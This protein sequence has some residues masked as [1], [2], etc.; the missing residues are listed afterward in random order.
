[1]NPQ[2]VTALERFCEGLSAELRGSESG[3]PPR[4][5]RVVDDSAVAPGGA[6]VET[7]ETTVDATVA[8]RVE[9]IADELLAGWRVRQKKLGLET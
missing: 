2:A 9:K 8:A 6:I 3:A 4:H 1:V 7:A 5:V